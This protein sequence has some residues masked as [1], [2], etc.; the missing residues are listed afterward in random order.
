MAVSPPIAA[1]S[2]RDRIV[3]AARAQLFLRGYSALTMDELAVDLGMS[4]K[5]L[6]QHFAGKE[7]LVRAAI[8]AFAREVRTEADRI[9]SDRRLTFAEKLRGLTG[10]L[11]QRLSQLSP[12]LFRDLQR[13]APVLHELVLELRR[14]NIPL[15]F[16]RL[17]EQGQANGKVRDDI[18]PGFAAEFLLHA[19][20][21]LMQ[22][23]SL[24]H[25]RLAPHETFERAMNLFFGGLLTP[26]GRKDY[27][28]LFGR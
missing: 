7:E 2:G 15:I 17:I 8:E 28:K 19:M 22:P 3:Q 20:Q 4:K 5:T 1:P 11:L 12:H 13:F 25:L 23:Q 21:G 14:K 24:D 18:D 10:G 16:G 26:A 9:L 27:E 6:Y